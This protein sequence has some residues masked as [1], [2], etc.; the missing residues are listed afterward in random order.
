M[1]VLADLL[2]PVME[3]LAPEVAMV[4]GVR[5]ILMGGKAQSQSRARPG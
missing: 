1:T 5:T 2:G 4:R 3:A